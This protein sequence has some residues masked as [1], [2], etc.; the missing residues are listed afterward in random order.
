MPER[1]AHARR[2]AHFWGLQA[3]TLAALWLQAQ[4]YRVIARNYRIQG[5]EIDIIARRGRTIVFVEV[6]ARADLEAAAHALTR[7]KEK[8]VARAANRWIAAHP[9]AAGCSWRADAVL[10]APRRLPRHIENAFALDFS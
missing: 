8:R 1:D 4:L 7:R 6:K 3:E 2:R 9:W 5:G 10:I